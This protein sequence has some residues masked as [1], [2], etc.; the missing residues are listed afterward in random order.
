MQ[1]RFLVKLNLCILAILLLSVLGGG[2]FGVYYFS[3]LYGSLVPSMHYDT[4]IRLPSPPPPPMDRSKEGPKFGETVKGTGKASTRFIGS[5]S[6]FRGDNYDAIA[7][8]SPPLKRSFGQS[9]PPKLWSIDVGEGY[10]GAAIR[11]GKVYVLD[12]DFVNRRDSL[13]CLSLDDAQEIWNFSY[14]VMI[15]KNHGVSR[16]IP[17]VSDRYCLTLGPMCHVACVNPNTG[18]LLWSRSL[19]EEYGT[20]VPQWYAGQCPM[21]TTLPGKAEEVAIIAPSGPETLMVAFDCANGEEIWKTPNPFGWVMTHTSIMPM[22][23]GERDTFV[24]VGKEGIVGVDAA[25]G[26]ILWSNHEWKIGMATCPSPL[27]LPGNRVFLCGGYSQPC[28]MLQI[29]D[30]GATA[31]PSQRYTAKILYRQR[32]T[33]FGS[34]QQTPLYFQDRIFGL[35]QLGRKFVCLEPN[36]GKVLWHSASKADLGSRGAGPYMIADGLFFILSDEGSL[37]IAEATAEEFRFL[38]SYEVIPAASD[39]WGPFAFADGLL[40]LRDL[41][42]MVCIDL[43]AE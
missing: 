14:P 19:V 31:E 13:R 33:V 34:E 40:I 10:A 41:T 17:A 18:E 28:A 16:T 4:S 37:I 20:I 12:Y 8:N 27:V 21:L 36:E 7:A 22:K 26:E 35:R 43:R 24:Y 29:H 6:R 30:H 2:A 39:A 23:L 32:D 25:S 42:R 38:G 15:S 5:W 1:A 11:N 9:G 3:Q